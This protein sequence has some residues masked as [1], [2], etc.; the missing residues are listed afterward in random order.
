MLLA[1]S[2][3]V[4]VLVVLPPRCFLQFLLK[5]F[6]PENRFEEGVHHLGNQPNLGYILERRHTSGQPA[7]CSCDDGLIGGAHL[8]DVHDQCGEEGVNTTS[9]VSNMN[10]RVLCLCTLT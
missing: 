5:R 9:A 3:V 2:I 1:A 10:P 7:L 6:V 8:V 4:L